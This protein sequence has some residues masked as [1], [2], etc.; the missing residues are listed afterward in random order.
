MINYL[1][2][3]NKTIKTTNGTIFAYRDIGNHSTTPL[4]LFNHLSGTLDNWDPRLVNNLAKERRVIT[5]DNKGI[6]LSSGKVPVSIKQMASDSLEFIHAMKFTKIDVLGF[7][8]G[9]MV[10]Q[11]LLDIEPTIVNK[12]MLAGTGPRG[13]VGIENVT[14]I[15]DCDLI[16]SIFTFK[17]IKTYLFFTNSNN[18][19]QKAKEFLKQIHL[20]KNDRDKSITWPAY[21]RQLKAINLWGKADSADLSKITQPTLIANGVD[22]IMV[23]ITNTYNLHDRIPN[24][25]LITYQD[26]GHAGIFQNYQDFSK[27]ALEFLNK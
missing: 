1:N 6:G 22:D 11:E 12:V 20:R 7:S 18:G 15:S 13:G 4:I 24:S 3:P 5:F 2:T 25:Q 14:R 26:A 19:K 23:P 16:K 9:G 21:R 27:N 8:M 17:D 10:V